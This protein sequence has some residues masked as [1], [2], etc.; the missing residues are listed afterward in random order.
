MFKASNYFIIPDEKMS[1]KITKWVEKFLDEDLEHA[2]MSLKRLNCPS[3]VL[4]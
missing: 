1:G 4:T 3:L 2:H